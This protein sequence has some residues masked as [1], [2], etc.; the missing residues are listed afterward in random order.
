MLLLLLLL[1][2]F[3]GTSDNEKQ[4]GESAVAIVPLQAAACREGV[5]RGG[6]EG[7][8]WGTERQQKGGVPFPILSL[9]R[10]HYFEVVEIVV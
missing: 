2:M 4:N 1:L 5:G 8:T 10:V 7:Q 3:L 9:S 6:G